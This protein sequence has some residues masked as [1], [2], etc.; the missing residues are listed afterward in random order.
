M[1]YW[2]LLTTFT[3]TLLSPLIT[4]LFTPLPLLS[5]PFLVCIPLH[6]SFL[7]SLPTPSSLP[8]TILAPSISAV[9]AYSCASF[10]TRMPL[11]AWRSFMAQ[12]MRV[13]AEGEGHGVNV[14]VLVHVC[15]CMCMC[16]CVCTYCT[17]HKLFLQI[18]RI[19]WKS[20]FHK[21][22][23]NVRALSAESTHKA[24]HRCCERFALEWQMHEKKQKTP[25][26][27]RVD[28]TKLFWT[29]YMYPR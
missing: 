26:V 4:L 9:L 10:S 23:Q 22:P 8:L 29:A 20:T 28:R 1:E 3:A 15:L 25:V 18:W 11:L 19:L 6:L 16:M 17:C 7:H 21:W 12:C 5:I 2:V 24:F 14:C 13:A 27:Q